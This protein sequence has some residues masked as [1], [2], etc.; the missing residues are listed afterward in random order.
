MYTNDVFNFINTDRYSGALEKGITFVANC[1]VYQEC[2]NLP[3]NLTGYLPRLEVKPTF[4]S[5]EIILECT[6]DNDRAELQAG[7][8]IINF[9]VS[10]EDTLDLPVGMFT[11]EITIKSLDDLVFRLS[12]GKFQIVA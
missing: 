4:A 3:D 7:R 8:G 10:A 9:I 2:S 6:I 5:E 1:Y 11:Y 12:Y